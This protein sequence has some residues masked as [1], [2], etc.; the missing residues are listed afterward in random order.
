MFISE[1]LNDANF[2]LASFTLLV[3]KMNNYN[4]KID[5]FTNSYGDMSNWFEMDYDT[6]T[7]CPFRPWH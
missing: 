7:T 1:F 3:Y 4:D 5:H 6:T 2:G